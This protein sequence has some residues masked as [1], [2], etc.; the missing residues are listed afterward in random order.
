L[1][2]YDQAVWTRFHDEAHNP[3]EFHQIDPGTG[4]N[5]DFRKNS[6][7]SNSRVA[8]GSFAEIAKA[9]SVIKDGSRANISEALGGNH[10]VRNFYNNIADPSNPNDVTIDTH[11]VAAGLLQ[12]LGGK[13]KEVLDNFG[14]AGKNVN[15]G[16]KGTYPLYADAYR[17]AAGELGIKARELQSVVWEKV[18]DL[19]PSEW[20]SPETEKQVKGI[21]KKYSDGK[22]TLDKTRE[23]IV[24]LAQ[25]AKQGLD[26]NAAD[27]L[28][29]ANQKKYGKNQG[30]SNAHGLL[31]YLE[32]QQP[33]GGMAVLAGG[34]Q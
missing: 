12:P 20:K 14:K 18:R 1:D 24:Q 9:I 31:D 5:L 3:R 11:A 21:W 30:V 29:K 6:N 33:R 34:G 15:T 32:S 4:D 2:T 7:G 26:A 28:A 23:E 10:K 19:F 17:Q 25:E 13:A 22:Q 27:S 8:W 16:V